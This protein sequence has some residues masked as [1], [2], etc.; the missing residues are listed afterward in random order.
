MLGYF[1]TPEG[2]SLLEIGPDYILAKV[3]NDLDVES[4]QLWP[5]ER[6]GR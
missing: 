1:E 6:G 5:L 3:R 4:V 2:M